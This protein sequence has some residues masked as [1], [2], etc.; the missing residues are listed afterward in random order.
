M[1]GIRIWAATLVSFRRKADKLAAQPFGYMYTFG[2]IRSEHID[3]SSFPMTIS[4][5]IHT[6]GVS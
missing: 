4:I 6:A 3:N 5:I 1:A 2:A